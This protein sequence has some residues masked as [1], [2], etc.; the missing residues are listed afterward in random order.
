MSSE[1]YLPVPLRMAAQ[2][3]QRGQS[4]ETGAASGHGLQE[5]GLVRTEVYH[6]HLIVEQL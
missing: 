4:Q 5:E 6:A 2:T 3:G 1:P